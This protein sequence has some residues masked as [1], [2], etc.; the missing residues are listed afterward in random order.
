MV[1]DAVEP[2]RVHRDT[3]SAAVALIHWRVV[4]VPVELQTNRA[5]R[6]VAVKG[7]IHLFSNEKL[8]GDT[9]RPALFVYSSTG[10]KST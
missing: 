10:M 3:P 7:V 9:T 1:I 4:L 6:M 5:A 2:L 8:G